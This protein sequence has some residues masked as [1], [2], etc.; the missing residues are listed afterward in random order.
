MRK[1][2]AVLATLAALACLFIVVGRFTW[3]SEPW[4]DGVSFWVTTDTAFFAGLGV[5][6]FSGLA[7]RMW[8]PPSDEEPIWSKWWDVA[9]WSYFAIGMVAMVIWHASRA[10]GDDGVGWPIVFLL[11]FFAILTIWGAIESGVK[12]WRA[13]HSHPGS[14]ATAH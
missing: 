13:S 4:E 10:G 11:G 12:A 14:G 8:Q 9:F 1:R 7:F 6:G 5:I 2:K 3:G